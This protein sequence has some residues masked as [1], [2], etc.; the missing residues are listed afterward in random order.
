[1]LERASVAVTAL[2]PGSGAEVT[3]TSQ[4]MA[5]SLPA[6]AFDVAVLAD[7]T[8][9][10][11]PVAEAD[12]AIATLFGALSLVPEQTALERARCEFDALLRLATRE[13][14]LARPLAGPDAEP[15]YPAVM[16]EELVDAYRA[17]PSDASEVDNPYRLPCALQ[18]CLVERGEELL[19]PNARAAARD[20]VQPARAEVFRP[21]L[22][23]LTPRSADK[24]A[25]Q[26]RDSAGNVLPKIC[27]SPSQIE[28]Y[29]ECPY[30]WFASRRLHLDT[31]DEGFGPLERGSFAHAAFEEFYR[32]FQGAGHAKVTPANLPQARALMRDV[33][34]EL[35]RRQYELEPDS[36][37]LVAASELERREVAALCEQLAGYL[38]FEAALLPTYHP[39]YLEYEIDADH[40]VDYA[41]ALLV[42]KV[43]RIDV[44]DAGHAVIIDYKGSVNAEHEIFGKAHGHAGKVQ[45]RIYAQAVARSLGLDV[46][47]AL[48]VS[49]GRAPSVS[50]AYD[51]R[52]LDAAHLP[53]VR[54]EKC[55]C[56]LLEQMPD[57]LPEETSLAS[58][59]FPAMLDET[60]D[61]VARALASMRQGDIA[62]R[63]AYPKACTYCPVLACPNRSA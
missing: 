3:V 40:A 13:V 61:I 24:V 2:A 59:T 17:D 9:D 8:S 35:A 6:G 33:A 14:V 16:L 48:Y 60:E 52:V 18:E 20:A 37:R 4:S 21:R 10:D 56:G 12:D 62:P 50:G 44:D 7:L 49:Y 29:L 43:D 51:P 53:G 41:G 45:T 54:A 38:D 5:A 58:L 63:P 39:A 34:G 46:V 26:R 55:A 31:V 57:V 27:P 19:F 30:Q 22:D 23:D 25:P 15:A 28:V 47:G 32:R 36:G 11:Y 42:G 1:M